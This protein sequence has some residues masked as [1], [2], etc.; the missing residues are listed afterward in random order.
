MGCGTGTVNEIEFRMRAAGKRL[1]L[2]LPV[3]TKGFSVSPEAGA[4]F[5]DQALRKRLLFR[6]RSRRSGPYLSY[7]W[8]HFLRETLHLDLERLELQHEQ[9]DAGSMKRADTCRNFVIAADESRR[10]AAIGADTR[11]LLHGLHHHDLRV[12]IA[13]LDLLHRRIL[14]RKSQQPL[15]LGLRFC[16]GLSRNDKGRQTESQRCGCARTGRYIRNQ[17]GDVLKRLAVDEPNVAVIGDQG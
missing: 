4:A 8:D 10:R 17:S 11:G 13:L 6:D 12:G 5:A 15:V 16:A 3:A 2:P 7:P 1:S 9:L 14:C